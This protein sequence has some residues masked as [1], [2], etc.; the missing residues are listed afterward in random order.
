MELVITRICGDQEC[1]E[2][3]VVTEEVKSRKEE[4]EGVF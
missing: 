3:Q 2:V 1:K 4:K